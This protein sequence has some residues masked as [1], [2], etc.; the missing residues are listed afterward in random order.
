MAALIPDR[1]LGPAQV[2]GAGWLGGWV[3]WRQDL[4]GGG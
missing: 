3:T 4:A 1:L 2:E